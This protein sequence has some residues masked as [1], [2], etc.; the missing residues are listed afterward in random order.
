MTNNNKDMVFGWVDT[1]NTLREVL[2]ITP[3]IK[4]E[5]FDFMAD[6]TECPDVNKYKEYLNGRVD[7]ILAI[8]A[9]GVVN[10]P[11]QE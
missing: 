9:K 5:L 2:V 4:Q 1:S 10:H 11:V 3:E 6:E 8:I 7:E